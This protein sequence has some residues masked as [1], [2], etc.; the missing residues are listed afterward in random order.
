MLG[1]IE[2]H[3]PAPVVPQHHEHEQDPK[4][5]RGYREEIQRHHQQAMLA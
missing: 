1:D 2:M 5:R 3:Q 4:A